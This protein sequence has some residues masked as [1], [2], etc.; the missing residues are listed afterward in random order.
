MQWGNRLIH[1]STG[2]APEHWGRF[3][4]LHLLIPLL[5]YAVW[6]SLFS[7]RV[8]VLCWFWMLCVMLLLR[9]LYSRKHALGVAMTWRLCD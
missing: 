5:H 8:I 2:M 3:A 4:F 6:S 1:F 9:F 7:S